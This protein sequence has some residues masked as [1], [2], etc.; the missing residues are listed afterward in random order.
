MPDTWLLQNGTLIDGTGASRRSG[1]V[2]LHGDRIAEVGNCEV[3]SNTRIIDCTGLIVAPGFMDAH[4]HS[5]LQVLEGRRD[6][7]RQGVTTEV[8]GNCGF[9][10]YP[11]ALDPSELR[12]FAGGI[13]C[14]FDE[15][16]WPSTESYL[17][18]VASS[19]TANV[20][21]LVGHGSLR[22]AVAG[23]KQG[24]L[25]ERDVS[26][27]E[28][29]LEEAFGAGAAGLSTGLMYAP[30]SSAPTEELRRL[31]RLTA[32]HGKVYTSH[33]RSYFADLVP[34]I[35]E[36]IDL[37]RHS[38]CRLQIS[39]LQAV[40]AANWPEHV[41]A[42]D[43]IERARKEEI[44]IAFDCYPYV[45]GSS[46]LT[47]LLPQWALDGGTGQML[48]RLKNRAERTRI[49]DEVVRAIAWRWS[50]IFISAVATQT[51]QPLIG[52]HLAEI[53]E[54][55]SCAPVDAMVD[56]LIEEAGAVNMVSFNQSEENLRLS[57]THPLA[58]IISDGFYVK[59]RAHPRLYGT[60]PL[61]LG[62]ICR[63]R[64]WLT[65]EDA[66]HKVTGRP[67]D[68]FHVAHRGLLRQGYF[69][70]LT[71]FDADAVDSPATYENP[72]LPPVGIR[73]VFRNGKWMEG[74]MRPN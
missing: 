30:G 64:G 41:K 35:E 57:L 59:G 34:A 68:R 50:D 44:D 72:E 74:S 48:S 56:L 4:S 65:L 31:C 10:A 45:A 27:M 70:D 6:K 7:L 33:I 1:N 24:P 9:S 36:Q 21:S 42:L 54:D 2:L 8:V 52:R 60:F 23:A 40:G 37:A 71:I 12:A 16:G 19:I 61:L 38:G 43:T 47:Q 25:P 49:A 46:I 29:L 14:R 20:V 53:A 28:A 67:A 62:E 69:A 3:S 63:R 11:P 73:C 17:K 15:W 39:H 22:I 32:K 66:I 26:R 58:I 55:R 5:D 18:A 51:N 13:F